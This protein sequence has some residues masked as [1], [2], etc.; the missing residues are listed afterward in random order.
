[1]ERDVHPVD[2]RVPDRDSCEPVACQG[3]EANCPH[4]GAT[5]E[6]LIEP[7]RSV[8]RTSRLR[9]VTVP[10][11]KAVKS[12]RSRP[13]SPAVS[14]A[15]ASPSPFLSAFEYATVRTFPSRGLYLSSSSP[16]QLDGPPPWHAE[17]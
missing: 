1:M 15:S 6:D 8:S 7:P 4:E 11:P 9:T 13:P 10:V 2:P 5:S 14:G 16:L 17:S 12:K 3:A